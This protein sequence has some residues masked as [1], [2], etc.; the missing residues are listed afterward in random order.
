MP[1]KTVRIGVRLSAD[2]QQQVE[3]SAKGQ[4]YVNPSAV[5]RAAI[6][7]GINECDGEVAEAEQRVMASLERLSREISRLH[8]GQQ[9]L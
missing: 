4:G 2:E 9:A 7:N 3:R 6:R 5:V 1:K 8:R